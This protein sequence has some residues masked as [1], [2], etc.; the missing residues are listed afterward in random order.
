MNKISLIFKCLTIAALTVVLVMSLKP[1]VSVGD[2]PHADK[3]LHFGAYAVLS[4]LARLGWPK[5]W[6]GFLF[7]GLAFFGIGIEMAQ[8]IMDLGRMGSLADIAANLLGA[9]IPL[10]FFHFFWTRHHT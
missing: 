4:V 10:I 5:R 6:G 9:A 8:H 7:L 1:S 3:L 2:V